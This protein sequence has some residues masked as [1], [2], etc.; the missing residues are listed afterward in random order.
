LFGTDCPFDPE[1][2]PLFIRETMKA[3]DSLRLKPGD[4]RR[5]YFGNAASLMRLELPKPRPSAKPRR[6]KSGRAASRGGR[7]R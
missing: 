1:G 7:G 4:R 2:G 6:A 5:L 3:I